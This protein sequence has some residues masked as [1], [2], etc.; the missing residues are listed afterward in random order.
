MLVVTPILKSGGYE[1]PPHQ[2]S[3]T[4]GNLKAGTD[5]LGY[6]NDYYTVR[7]HDDRVRIEFRSAELMKDGKGERQAHPR[8]ALFDLPQNIHYIRLMRLLRVSQADHNMAIL[9]ADDPKSLA[10]LTN[11]VEDHP[12][13][14][15][16]EG[17]RTYC[18]WVP[19]GIAVRAEKRETVEGR[20][21]W[22]PVS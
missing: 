3:G 10:D 1:L 2:F 9:G 7:G 6:E 12:D 16:R 14:G 11:D 13:T 15:C 8:A 20:T 17:P 5:F 22:I 19:Q 21:D 4:N 18:F